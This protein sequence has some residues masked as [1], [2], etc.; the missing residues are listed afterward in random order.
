MW[1]P[2]ESESLLSII[3]PKTGHRIHNFLPFLA[4]H[5]KNF[6]LEYIGIEIGHFSSPLSGCVPRFFTRNYLQLCDG[7]NLWRS[8]NHSEMISIFSRFFSSL[9]MTNIKVMS[10]FRR[11]SAPRQVANS[12]NSPSTKLHQ[13]QWERKYFGSFV[14]FFHGHVFCSPHW[15]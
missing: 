13:G 9:I 1:M 12:I 3:Q 11:H 14:F 7:A 15:G 5:L 8:R 4:V 6:C 10:F 2:R